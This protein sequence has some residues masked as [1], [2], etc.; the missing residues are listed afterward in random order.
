MKRLKE[1]IEHYQDLVGWVF[2]SYLFRFIKN[3]RI[4]KIAF[5]KRSKTVTL[6]WSTWQPSPINSC[7]ALLLINW[8]M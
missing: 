1:T 7:F 6:A 4:W 2:E 3:L 5:Q 8:Q